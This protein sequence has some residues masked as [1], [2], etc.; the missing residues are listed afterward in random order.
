MMDPQL[1]E[2]LKKI[3]PPFN[4]YIAKGVATH[5]IPLMER[6]ID[7]VMRAASRSFPAGMKYL[8]CR[9]CTPEQE[10]AIV[11]EKRHN[12]FTYELAPS[13]VFLVAYRFSY[14]DQPLRDRHLYLPFVGQAGTLR[15]RGPLYTISPV[16][17]D[18]LISATRNG[19]FIPFTRDKLTF[20]RLQYA[21]VANDIAVKTY[22]TWSAVH[23]YAE[24]SSAKACA[25]STLAHYLF[26]KYGM[27]ETFRKFAG[28][29]I[30]VGGSEINS[31]TH[32]DDQWVVCRTLGGMPRG[33]KNKAYVANTCVVA[34]R[35]DQFTPLVQALLAGFFYVAD[36]FPERVRPEV[37]SSERLWRILMGYVIFKDGQSEGKLATDVDFHMESLDF[38]VDDLVRESLVKLGVNV[39][40][41]Y[42]L[43]VYI[44]EN[45][46]DIVMKA[47]L[48]SVYNKKLSVL[49][50]V[51]LDIVKKI[52]LMNYK[53]NSNSTRKLTAEDINK[54][55]AQFLNRELI[56]NLTKG[57]GECSGISSPGD[58]MAFKFTSSA[59]MQQD[60]TGGSR[61][62]NRDSLADPSRLFHASVLEFFSYLH[63]PK[64]NPTGRARLN[65][66]AKTDPDGTMVRDPEKEARLKEI[67]LLTQR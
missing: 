5:Q 37:C 55:T 24:D 28:A 6:Y 43:F 10:Y 3:I 14:N 35:K 30:I 61:R 51:A 49:R 54:L 9:R 33:V 59:V 26:C 31:R 32:P 22:I 56:F 12:R 17:A 20:E 13:D 39:Q 16:L 27:Q 60:A 63:L 41:T 8:G 4:P 1:Y 65:L 66:R 38:Y 52:F 53:L 45:I 64:S 47:D 2:P 25:L 58:N 67:E 18:E 46:S 11:T 19:I 34:V 50:Y 23:S 15:M 48:S 21:F 57:H 7:H 42:E 40:D 62:R 29:D 36:Y 44:I